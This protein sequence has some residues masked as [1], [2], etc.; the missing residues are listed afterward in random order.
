LTSGAGVPTAQTIR[1]AL[2]YTHRRPEVTADVLQMLVEA[3]ARRGVELRFDDDEVAKHRLAVSDADGLRKVQTGDD[4]PDVCIVLGGDGTTLRFLR[5]FSGTGVPIFSV[6]CGRVGF[7][8]TVDRDEAADGFER[9]LGGDFEVVS[10]PSLVV[11]GQ[12]EDDFALNE[13]S[14]QR[15][16][17]MNVAH[18]SYLLAG[19]EVVR[20]PCDGLIAA[21]P[22]GSTAYNLSAGGPILA[23]DLRGYVVNMVAPH[24][25]SARAVVAGPQDVLEVRNNGAEKVEVVIDGM[26]RGALPPN[27]SRQITFHPDAVGLAQLPGSTFYSRF[28][29]KLRLLTGG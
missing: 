25:L 16:A 19:E 28:Q 6:N 17:H 29:K 13:V 27:E 24:A 1:S 20:A 10:L 5:E 23:W 21:T 14:F 2:V 15:G 26:P 8:A 12:S 7:L 11:G 4:P 9:A 22:V 18:L 3:A